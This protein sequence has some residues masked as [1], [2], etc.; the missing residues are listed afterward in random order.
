MVV[1]VRQEGVKVV[2][3]SLEGVTVVRARQEESRG[4]YGS[5]GGSHGG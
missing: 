2:K 4:S 5:T 1:R 3:V